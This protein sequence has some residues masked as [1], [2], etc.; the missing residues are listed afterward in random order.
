MR[1]KWVYARRRGGASLELGWDRLA[2]LEAD[3]GQ[4]N[5]PDQAG[6]CFSSLV[7]PSPSDWISPYFGQVCNHELGRSTSGSCDRR[8]YVSR[9]SLRVELLSSADRRP[10]PLQALSASQPP[11]PSK[12]RVTR[13]SSSLSTCQATPKR[14]ATPRHGPGPTM[15]RAPVQTTSACMVSRTLGNGGHRPRC[16]LTSSTLRSRRRIRQGRV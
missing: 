12:Q 15:F 5:R 4:V 11:L 6:P 3:L 7:S 8:R 10:G 14:L 2:E 13:Y 1:F 9:V 16:S